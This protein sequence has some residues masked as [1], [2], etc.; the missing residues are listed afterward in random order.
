M[1]EADRVEHSDWHVAAALQREEDAAASAAARARA[2]A[3]KRPPGG[4]DGGRGAHKKRPRGQQSDGQQ[5]TLD[6]LFLRRPVS[7]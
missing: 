4:A 6:S 5:G 3:R 7:K 2:G 1:A